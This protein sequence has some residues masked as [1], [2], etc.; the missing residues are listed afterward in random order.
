MPKDSLS[1]R[2]RHTPG[3]PTPFQKTPKG[4]GKFIAILVS[5][6][7]TGWILCNGPVNAMKWVN[8]L[9]DEKTAT[10]FVTMTLETTPTVKLTAT[11]DSTPTVSLP[12]LKNFPCVDSLAFREEAQLVKVVDGDTIIV[13]MNGVEYR[14]RYI[15][16]DSPEVG[17]P[18]SEDATNLNTRLLGSGNLVMIKDYSE[19]DRFDR[20]LRYVFADDVFVNYEMVKKGFA[21]SGSW[22]PD[23]AC[24]STFA[25]SM[26]NA[27]SEKLGMWLAA[28][29]AFEPT[30]TPLPLIMT[31]APAPSG[32]SCPNGC[33]S[34]RPGC[35]IK[36]NINSDGDK[37]YHM[38]WQSAYDKTVISPEKGEFWFCTEAEAEVNGWRKAQN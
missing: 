6:F 36:G 26:T 34:E 13:S 3:E 37:I 30:K 1:H 23:T 12:I 7:G 15:G 35:S 29:L 28:P 22:P 9:P 5:L 32:F 33:Q 19:V 18:Y 17:S 38:P 25:A 31:S 16:I 11:I 24:D 4:F 2:Y 20:L 21:E 10:P 8:S 14:V 27:K